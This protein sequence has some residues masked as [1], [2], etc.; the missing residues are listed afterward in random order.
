MGIRAS[1]AGAFLV[2]QDEEV[3]T[4]TGLIEVYVLS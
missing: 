1:I 2:Y 4:G 3:I